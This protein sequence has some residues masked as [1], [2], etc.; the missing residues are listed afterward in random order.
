MDKV[1]TPVAAIRAQCLACAKGKARV[2]RK[3]AK[4]DC[5]LFQYR[6]GCAKRSWRRQVVKE[7]T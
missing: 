1:L 7:A 4:Q 5:P 6:F 3:C 2:V